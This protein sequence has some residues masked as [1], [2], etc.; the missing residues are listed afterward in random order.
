MIIPISKSRH[1]R[2]P[3]IFSGDSLFYYWVKVEKPLKFCCDELK[4]NY[5]HIEEIHDGGNC[6]DFKTTG[7]CLSTDPEWGDRIKLNFCPSC[8]EIIMFEDI[9]E[10]S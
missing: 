7:V 1:Q 2:D 5:E 8:G 9:G 6:V 3:K 4:Q 10:V